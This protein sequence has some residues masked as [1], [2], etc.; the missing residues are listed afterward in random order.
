MFDDAAPWWSTAAT[1]IYFAGLLGT[2]GAATATQIVPDAS[3]WAVR[4]ATVLAAGVAARLAAQILAAFGEI[5]ITTERIGLL[6]TET[7]WGW[8]WRWQA[9]AAA[10]AIAAAIEVRRAP[11]RGKVFLGCGLAAS[12]TAALTGHAVAFPD[13][14]W[15]TVPIHAMHVGAA[16]VWLGTLFVLLRTVAL[17][18]REPA[19]A[20]RR[21][22]LSDAVLRFSL[23]AMA[24]VPLLVAS[25]LLAATLHVGTF[26]ALWTT[27]YGRVLLLKVAFFLGA[28]ACGA[29]NWRRIGPVL[30]DDT[31]GERRLRSVGGLEV[32]LGLVAL[33]LTSI[34]VAL[35]MPAEL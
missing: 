27:S 7:P 32:G 11:G 12:V 17:A 3:R 25:G 21:H 20:V 18:W 13:R 31:D 33:L 14:V 1:F 23:L 15:L 28:A 5:G 10:A 22:R 6:I 8:G 26:N 30:A 19:G 24:A 16:G 2:V 35:P 34:L 29:V 9:A 4:A